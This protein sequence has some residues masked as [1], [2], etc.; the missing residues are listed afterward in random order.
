M[1]FGVSLNFMAICPLRLQDI[2][3][4][5]KQ[6]VH[7]LGNV[8]SEFNETLLITNWYFMRTSRTFSVMV[9]LVSEVTK[10]INIDHLG[11]KFSWK[12]ANSC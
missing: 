5:C 6:R 11:N 1:K 3:R 7:P 4:E 8:V 12:S 2:F 10:N 9:A